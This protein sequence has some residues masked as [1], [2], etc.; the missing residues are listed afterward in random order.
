M[1]I[2]RMTIGCTGCSSGPTS[3]TP[4]LSTT[5]WPFVTL[6]SSA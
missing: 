5:S 3:T 4:I 1:R 2:W 6:P